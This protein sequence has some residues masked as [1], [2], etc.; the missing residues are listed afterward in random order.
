M[1]V[2]NLTLKDK[3]NADLLIKKKRWFTLRLKVRHEEK[4][5]VMVWKPYHSLHVSGISPMLHATS[6][7]F[8]AIWQPLMG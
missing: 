1:I 8:A 7:Q 2:L 6:K 3:T 4:D 5:K